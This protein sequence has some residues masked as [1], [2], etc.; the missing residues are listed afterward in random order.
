MFIQHLLHQKKREQKKNTHT[1]TEFG[2]PFCWTSQQR[3]QHDF[4]RCPNGTD[5]AYV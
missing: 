1:Q 3:L 2:C 5:H 4:H